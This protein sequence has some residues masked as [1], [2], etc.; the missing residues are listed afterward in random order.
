MKDAQVRSRSQFH[1]WIYQATRGR[2]GRRLVRN[3]ML[4]LTT[5]GRRTGERHTVPLLYL[6][7]GA[8]PVVI[9]SYGGRDRHPEWYLNL[10]AEPEVAVQVSGEHFA[11]R[12]RTADPDERALWWP[13]AVAAYGDYSRYQS[14][15]EREIPVVFL[16]RAN[17]PGAD[18]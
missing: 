3:D 13:R 15:T 12:A 16:E 11:A 9:A 17:E 18:L 14:R 6:R 10:V 1:R 7:D 2:I 8:N 4:L 5:V